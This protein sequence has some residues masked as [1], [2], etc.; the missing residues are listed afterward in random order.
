M[1]KKSS[2]GSKIKKLDSDLNK[3]FSKFIRMRDAYRFSESTRVM[4]I[5]CSHT[6]YWKE[7]DAGHFISRRH[8]STK[9]NE[10]NVNAQ[11]KG[12]N[13]FRSGN[14]FEHAIA[15]DRKYGKGISN[16]LL[17]ESKKVAKWAAWEY[18]QRIIYYKKEVEKLEK[19]MIQ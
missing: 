7:F 17:V 1:N 13:N 4:C 16:I 12:C 15:V 8:L 10:M 9:F 5:T 19:L 2:V 11:C 14:Q 6:G 18:E 3:V